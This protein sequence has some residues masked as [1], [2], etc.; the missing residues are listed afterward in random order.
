[1]G[2]DNQFDFKVVNVV[3]N[4]DGSA[5]YEFEYSDGFADFFKESTGKEITEESF[6][7]FMT[8][9]I[10][11]NL[12]GKGASNVIPMTKLLDK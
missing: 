2:E 7:E 11:E 9:A 5:S 8:N 4:N 6:Q 3:P 10:K 12:K 1:M